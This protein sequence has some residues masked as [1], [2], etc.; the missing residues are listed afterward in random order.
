MQYDIIYSDALDKFKLLVNQ[1]LSDNWQ[2]IG[3]INICYCPIPNTDPIGH[4][5]YCQAIIKYEE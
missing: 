5:R 2:L 1:K 3:G 4:I